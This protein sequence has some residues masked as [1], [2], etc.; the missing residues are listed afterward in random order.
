M[1]KDKGR[2]GLLLFVTGSERPP[3]MGFEFLKG[4]GVNN[5]AKFTIHCNFA[6]GT[7]GVGLKRSA[8]TFKNNR[9]R[10]ELAEDLFRFGI[11]KAIIMFFRIRRRTLSSIP[12]TYLF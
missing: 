1:H 4:Y 2:S 10:S 8:S 3:A 7:E 6:I 9:K 12:R 11:Q 5:V